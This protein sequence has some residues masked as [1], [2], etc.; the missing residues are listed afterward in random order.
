MKKQWVALGMAGLLAMG[1]LTGCGSEEK[2]TNADATTKAAESSDTKT[3]EGTEANAE[4]PV[5]VTW[6]IFGNKQ[7]DLDKVIEDLNTKLVEKI[8]VKLNLEVIP[9]GEFNDKMKLKST[10]GEDYDIVFTSNWLNSFSDN[11]S[12]EAFLP[13]DELFEQY[14]QGIRAE[15]PEWLLDV[16][17]VDGKMYAVPNQ[18]IIARQLGVAIQ[19]EYAE[20]YGFDKTSLTSIRDLE[21]FLDEIVKNEP[22]MFPIDSRVAAVVEE[23]YEAVVSVGSTSGNNGDCVL[24]RKDDSEASLV[25]VADVISDQLKLDHEWY[26]KGYLRKDIATVMDNT[27][28]VKANRYVC[29]LSSYKPGWDSE[30]T[31]RQGVEYITVPIEG[32]YVKANSGSETMNAINVNSKNPEAAMKLMNLMYTDKE[33]FNEL[34]FGIEGEHYT[35]TGENS[36]EL[37]SNASESKYTFSGYA[38]MLGNQF[39]AYY[40]PGQADGL[41][42]ETDKLNKEAQISPLR[43]F[44]FDPSNVQ[45]ELAQVGAVVKEYANGQFNAKDI[46][47]YIAERNAKM[48]QAGLSAI[49]EETQRQIDA[50]KSSK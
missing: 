7:P 28:D 23:D 43:G 40:M 42:E 44:V 30:M 25:S 27:A 47:A 19:K 13:L 8:N 9:Q 18:Q 14:G 49:M 39:K 4:E 6:C 12:R 21:P 48:E 5:T 36:V 37:T 41:W 22:S 34:V 26:Q 32:I 35:K 24:I 29:T 17:K 50:W 11:M 16:G 45:S 31:T 20:K 38:W 10:A 1:S 2:S 46:D 3:T 33:I 15:V